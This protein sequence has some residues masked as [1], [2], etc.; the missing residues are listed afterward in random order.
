MNEELNQNTDSD[1]IHKK[2]EKDVRQYDSQKQK[3]KKERNEKRMPFL[4]HLEE[5]RWCLIRSIISISIASIIAFIFASKILT[6]LMLPYIRLPEELRLAPMQYLSPAGGF[7]MHIKVAVF[8]GI[9][10]AL[11]YVFY[12]IWKFVVPGLL[13]KERKYAPVI[14]SATTICFLMGAVFAFMII[15]PFGLRFLFAYQ[16]KW[17]VANLRI[18]DYL[19]F[20]TRVILAF[21]VVFELPVISFILTRIGILTPR[22]LTS[23]RRYSIVLIF[24]V[25]AIL[26]PPDPLTQIMM[27]TP[28]LVL[29][30]VSIV[31][32]KMVY[33]KESKANES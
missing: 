12:E 19:S 28:L 16:T 26:T 13:D 31:V 24:V 6:L 20:V 7:M 30:E 18:D 33:R 15:L 4:D 29:Y 25:A 11:P 10:I 14:I 23:K 21:G 27:A 9:I 32:S 22:F 2:D 5:L 8:A 17:M 1:N 3:G